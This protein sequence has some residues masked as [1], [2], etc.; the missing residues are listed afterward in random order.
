MTSRF[1]AHVMPAVRVSWCAWWKLKQ[2]PQPNLIDPQW[3]Y[4][5]DILQYFSV[6]L[7]FRLHNIFLTFYIVV[8]IGYPVWAN[9][10]ANCCSHNIVLVRGHLTHSKYSIPGEQHPT[11]LPYKLPVSCVIW[12]ALCISVDM[13]PSS[14][15][16]GKDYRERR[17]VTWDAQ[18]CGDEVERHFLLELNCITSPC[19]A[20]ES[21]SWSYLECR[22]SYRKG[23]KP[24]KHMSTDVPI[25]ALWTLTCVFRKWYA[26]AAFC[27]LLLW[28]SLL[29][30][31][32]D[33]L[34]HMFMARYIVVLSG[35]PAWANNYWAAK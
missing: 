20:H 7:A 14:T 22:R 11:H 21:L 24:N 35:K 9:N 28:E 16:R 19:E 3:L 23:G 4:T 17:N 30:N 12:R 2:L 34:R 1:L 10:N 15:S 29:Y 5:P 31:S 27:K 18:L 13:L 26:I 25:I 6:M 8:F 32:I 33:R